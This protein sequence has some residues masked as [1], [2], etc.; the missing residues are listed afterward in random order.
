MHI[1]KFHLASQLEAAMPFTI[2]L[3]C[4]IEDRGS[5]VSYSVNQVQ[6]TE[7]QDTQFYYYY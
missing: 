7:M 4:L 6:N 5:R 1:I 3:L 2:S